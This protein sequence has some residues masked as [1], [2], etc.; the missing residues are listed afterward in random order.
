MKEIWEQ[1]VGYEGLYDVSNL[2]NVRS[3]KKRGASGD[4]M[5][6]PR[7]MIPCVGANGYYLVGLRKRTHKG[8]KRTHFGVHTLVLAAFDRP[9]PDKWCAR[10]LDGNKL[11]NRIDNLEWS[12]Y[13]TNMMDK[14]DH[15]RMPLG[16]NH[17][18][19]KYSEGCIK[20]IKILL[21]NGM[22]QARIARSLGVPRD[23]VY[24]IKRK[25]TWAWVTLPSA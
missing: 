13:S 24:D 7:K 3:W 25:K 8:I 15:G 16:E 4:V 2:G 19:S 23:L 10:H 14:Y 21:K 20:V 9:K 1:V 17:P 22:K 11:N 5:D 18:H 6:E 12:T